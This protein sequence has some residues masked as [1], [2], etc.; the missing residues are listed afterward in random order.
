MILYEK[1]TFKCE[2][3]RKL[4]QIKSACERHE[5][6]CSKNPNNERACFGCKFCQKVGVEV[7]MDKVYGEFTRNV[8]LLMCKKKD[9]YLVPPNAHHRGNFIE[10]EDIGDGSKENKPMPIECGDFEY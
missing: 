6:A 4:Y 8:S 3:C 2:H 7:T 1:T 9:H 10:G 5:K